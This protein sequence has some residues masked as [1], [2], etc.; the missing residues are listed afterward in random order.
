[1]KIHKFYQIIS[2]NWPAKLICFSVAVLISM[3]YGMSSVDTR[4]LN[5]P[6]KII[7]AGDYMTADDV[8]AN[9]RVLLR[10]NKDDIYSITTSEL[11]AY[12]DF[13]DV[14]AAGVYERAIKV[15][16][17]G[18]AIHVTP[19]EISVEPKKVRY[20]FEDKVV[21]RVPLSAVF[22]GMPEDGYEMVSSFLTPDYATIQGPAS[23][24][25]NIFGMKTVPVNVSGRSS[26][27]TLSV[28]VENS[29][30][31][32]IVSDDEIRLNVHISRIRLSRNFPHVDITLQNVAPEFAVS[33]SAVSGSMKIEAGSGDVDK[34]SSSLLYLTGDLSGITKAGKYRIPLKPSVPDGIDVASF[35][36]SYVEV[37]VTAQDKSDIAH[38]S[39]P[40]E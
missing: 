33:A 27:F 39:K 28:D 16:R 10:G 22:S 6:F 14:A 18:N 2:R 12:A 8:V 40:A 29:N 37:T 31:K 3:I 15:E 26:D 9:V 38:E 4:Y 17:L 7:S 11:N 19:L 23:V 32:I 34:V 21:K 25:E 5:I 13:S 1:M 24:V 30:H 35:T 20:S 36:P